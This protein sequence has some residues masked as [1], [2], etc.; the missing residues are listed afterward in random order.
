MIK[1]Y[2]QLAITKTRKKILDVLNAG[3]KSLDIE[4]I[5]N[6]QINLKENLLS[7]KSEL[8]KIFKY[9]LNKFSRIFLIGV[10]KG[11][12]SATK[13]IEKIL[14][15]RINQGIVIDIEKK[16][17]KYVKSFKGTHPLPS[18][19]NLEAT[20][21]IMNMLKI[22]K[23]ND[24]VI[25]LIFGGGSALLCSPAKVS[26]D[27]LKKYTQQ[28]INSG[29][30]IRQ[31]NTIR[32]HLSLIKGGQLAKLAFPAEVISCISSDV[33]G[34]NLS[35]I[36]SGPTVKDKT[37]IKDVKKI[38]KEFNWPKNILIETPRENKYFKK[39]ENILMFSNHRPLLRMKK[40]A[41]ELGFKVNIYS[42]ALKGEAKKVGE[43]LLNLI[44]K[45][46]NKKFPQIILA[47]G[48]TT[49][50][51]KAKGKGGRNQELVLGALPLLK[52]KEIIIS[53]A[54]DGWD[55]TKAAGA[56]GDIKTKQKA[57]KLN[58]TPERFLENN[59]SFHFFQKTNDLIFVKSG[60][61]VADFVIL[62][63]FL[64]VFLFIFCNFW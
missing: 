14:G 4:K 55:N 20:Q 50:K 58:L 24:L 53:I 7:I 62:A 60:V 23:S 57:E 59:N 18:N 34:N 46:R 49:V 41:K 42:Y 16:S 26:L 63:K 5:I 43:K 51:V 22:T 38:I 11:S 52:N 56:I 10:G 40:K 15:P 54:S 35:S 6:E 64:V 44:H 2:K 47:G 8:G 33:I 9:D 19:K 13:E 61:N 39:V 36:A 31:I 45:A 21:K 37:K 32:K 12:A 28:L 48:E 3:L 29:K 17:L 27:E 30:D 1:N 25:F